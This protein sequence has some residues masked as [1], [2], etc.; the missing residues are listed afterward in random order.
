MKCG[1]FLL[2]KER[3]PCRLRRRRKLEIGVHLWGFERQK[4]YV[5][6]LNL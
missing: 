5:R 4:V 6:L 3:K 2:L 1:A